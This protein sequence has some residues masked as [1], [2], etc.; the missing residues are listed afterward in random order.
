MIPGWLGVVAGGVALVGIMWW[1]EQ[2]TGR[3]GVTYIIAGALFLIGAVLGIV[4]GG[5][6]LPLV[7]IVVGA[8]LS[9]F[10]TSW[11]LERKTARPGLMY[12][13]L[14]FLFLSAAAIGV[15]EGKW[16]LSLICTVQAT[17]LLYQAKWKRSASVDVDDHLQQKATDRAGVDL[18]SHS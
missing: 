6:V 1:L 11:W 16:G 5:Q 9:L 3:T 18:T 8:G 2:L 10:G 4:Q 15:V 17:V 14:A 12:V 13:V 7:L